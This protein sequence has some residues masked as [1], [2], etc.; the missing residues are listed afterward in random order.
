MRQ[1]SLNHRRS[2]EHR[3]ALTVE[4]NNIDFDMLES[5][6]VRRCEN[7]SDKAVLMSF[8]GTLGSWPTTQCTISD[9]ATL[10]GVRFWQ[11]R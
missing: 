1:L 4:V 10:H 8:C 2:G 5:T 3:E 11:G 7:G 9:D 6:E